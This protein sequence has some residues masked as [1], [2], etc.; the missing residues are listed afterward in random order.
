MVCQYSLCLRRKRRDGE[1]GKKWNE[2]GAERRW[3]YTCGKRATRAARKNLQP[4]ERV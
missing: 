4:H 1:K 2:N 3:E